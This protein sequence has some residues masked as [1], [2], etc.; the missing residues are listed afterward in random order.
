MNIPPQPLE[1][2]QA[3]TSPTHPNAIFS[4]M[5]VLGMMLPI[6]PLTLREGMYMQLWV[7]MISMI[8]KTTWGTV[9]SRHKYTIK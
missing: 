3:H 5:F 7:P 6:L 1:L 9:I 8:L 4:S 2:G